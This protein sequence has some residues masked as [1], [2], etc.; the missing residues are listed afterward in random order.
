MYMWFEYSY[1]TDWPCWPCKHLPMFISILYEVNV[2]WIWSLIQVSSWYSTCTCCMNELF[3]ISVKFAWKLY[4]CTL[5]NYHTVYFDNLWKNKKENNS[6]FFCEFQF[7]DNISK[8]KKR[9]KTV[10]YLPNAQKPVHFLE[11]NY[12]GPSPCHWELSC[13]GQWSC[14]EYN[15][16]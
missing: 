13:I 2:I 14:N 8:T 4:T 3:E 6:F 7:L 1:C 11:T 16:E 12:A 5:R 15:W 10:H 9:V